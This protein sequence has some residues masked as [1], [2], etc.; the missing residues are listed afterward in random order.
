MS[1][2]TTDILILFIAARHM[3]DKIHGNDQPQRSSRSET[4]VCRNTNYSRRYRERIRQ[5]P[6]R[7]QRYRE[8]QLLYQLR[9]KAKRQREVEQLKTRGKFAT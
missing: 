6:E 4:Y 2:D 9:H 7:Y 3:A 1:V 5:D 8:K